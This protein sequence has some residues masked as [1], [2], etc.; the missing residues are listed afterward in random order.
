MEIECGIR[1]GRTRNRV[2]VVGEVGGAKLRKR[3]KSE[4]HR[5]CHYLFGGRGSLGDTLQ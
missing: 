4:D 2:W 5:F 3:S 1:R